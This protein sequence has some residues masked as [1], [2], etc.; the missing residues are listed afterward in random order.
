MNKICFI[1][2]YLIS[3]SYLGV[4]GIVMYGLKGLAVAFAAAIPISGLTVVISD[5]FGDLSCTLFLDPK[6]N[7]SIRERLSRDLSRAR[8]QK[9]NGNYE[10]ALSIIDNVLD[11]VPNFKKPLFI[12]AQIL[13][14][15][16]SDIDR[17]KK[18]F[19]RILEHEPG[20]SSLCCWAKY[21]IIQ[22]E[23]NQSKQ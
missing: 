3:I 2:A 7:W 9:M 1:R 19:A 8:V 23:K 15:G 6:S 22:I 13:L 18:Y 12:K 20:H 11:Q 17:A 4:I 14:D 21:S 10:K 5:K 16:Y